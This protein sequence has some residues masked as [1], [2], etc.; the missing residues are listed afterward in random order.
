MR[1][2]DCGEGRCRDMFW[3]FIYI[4]I[5][6]VGILFLTVLIISVLLCC[7]S[8]KRKKKFTPSEE[9]QLIRYNSIRRASHN[10]RQLSHNRDTPLLLRLSE[11]QDLTASLDRDSRYR[12]GIR[13]GT[14]TAPNT[15]P[16]EKERH[17]R[18]SRHRSSDLIPPNY[19]ASQECQPEAKLNPGSGVEYAEVHHGVAAEGGNEQ[20]IE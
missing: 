12:R 20:V 16:R 3:E 5:I 19:R 2:L 11:S 8:C 14:S 13:P 7:S 18:H 1:Q 15:L 6:P 4:I 17:H 10:L 9:T